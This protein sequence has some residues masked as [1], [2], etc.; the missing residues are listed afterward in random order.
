MSFSH[1][2][3]RIVKGMLLRGDKQHDIA[4]TFLSMAAGL[5]KLQQETAYIR[6]RNLSQQTSCR[7]QVPTF[8]SMHYRL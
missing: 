8:Q 3:T 7:R 2:E 5:E 4:R 6:M 1:H